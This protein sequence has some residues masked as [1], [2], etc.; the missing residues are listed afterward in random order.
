[1]IS[2]PNLLTS[3]N[4]VC[5]LVAIITGS[6]VPIF[7]GVIFDTLDG[8]SARALQKETRFGAIFDSVADF[9]TFGVAPV[10]IFY[11]STNDFGTLTLLASIFYL[12]ACAYRLIRFHRENQYLATGSFQG[13]PITASGFILA[14]GLPLGM[15]VWTLGALSLLMVSRIRFEKPKF[16]ESY[17]ISRRAR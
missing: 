2:L 12:S 9:V 7:L 13:L 5:G 1:M 4:L 3:F 11:R 14:L 8:V 17:F 6:I 15:P 10:I 16:Y